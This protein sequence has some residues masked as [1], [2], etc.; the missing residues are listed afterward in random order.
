[1]WN[2]ADVSKN[3]KGKLWAI[4]QKGLE[5]CIFRFDV[6]SFKGQTP[7]CFTNYE[8]LNLDNLN[9][10]QLDN[11]GVKYEECNNAGFSRIA[12]L[13]WRLDDDRHK[14]YI[15]HMFQHIR[16]QKP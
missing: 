5:I 15:N 2:K 6:H 9:T 10:V 7:N 14:L 12:L 1:M 16:S 8:P 4:G 11:L 13:K 3:E